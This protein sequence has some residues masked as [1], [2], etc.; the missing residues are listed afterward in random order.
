MRRQP[1][2][3]FFVGFI[4][5]VCLQ[6]SRQ[7]QSRSRGRA[8]TRRPFRGLSTALV[9]ALGDPNNGNDA[10]DLGAAAKSTG[11]AAGLP[12]V[13]TVFPNP[14]TTFSARGNVNTSPGGFVE[15]SRGT[16]T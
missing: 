9:T 2:F 11:T 12:R 1:G 10:R 8:R 15:Q 5:L 4:I 6:R 7:G 13:A 3:A 14:Q 16:L